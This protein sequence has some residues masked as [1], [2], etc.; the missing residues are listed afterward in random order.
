MSLGFNYNRKHR[1]NTLPG[2]VN[3]MVVRDRRPPAVATVGTRRKSPVSAAASILVVGPNPVVS[4]IVSR[5]TATTVS[6]SNLSSLP[7]PPPPPTS[8]DSVV[9]VVTEEMHSVFATV[10]APLTDESGTVVAHEGSRVVL[11]YPMTADADDG[12][13]TMKMKSVNPNTAQLS[14]TTVTVYDP[15]TE[16]RYAT[17]FS[18]TP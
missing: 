1:S 10:A 4:A 12:R 9:A 13:I 7:P 6:S 2:S 3:P 8:S 17:D 5:P 18:L 15:N 11:V 14:Y 16:T